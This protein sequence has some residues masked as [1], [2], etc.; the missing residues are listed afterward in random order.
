MNR[1][2]R[3]ADDLHPDVVFDVLS[4]PYRRFVLSYLAQEAR[5]IPMTELADR[6]AAWEMNVPLAHVG[7]EDRYCAR[8]DLYH[9]H[10]PKLVDVG[11]VECTQE[12]DRVQVSPRGTIR[13]IKADLPE[14]TVP[15]RVD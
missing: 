2:T 13:T 4:H 6:A 10:L 11:L 1:L 8:L 7:E 5:S 14:P 15:Y 12:G 3:H 9:T